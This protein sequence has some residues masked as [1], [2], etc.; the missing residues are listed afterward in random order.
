[1]RTNVNL[2]PAKSLTKRGKTCLPFPMS[3]HHVLVS[4]LFVWFSRCSWGRNFSDIWPPLPS[5]HKYS[6]YFSYLNMDI[7]NIHIH[8]RSIICSIQMMYWFL[9]T[10]LE[11]LCNSDTKLQFMVQFHLCCISVALTEEKFSKW[12]GACNRSK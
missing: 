9:V 10:P 6:T 3:E 2:F 7:M 8:L 11:Q 1:M 5:L 4:R 12:N